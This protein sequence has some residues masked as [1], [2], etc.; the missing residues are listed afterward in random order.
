MYCCFIGNTNI[1][2]P[3]CN[4]LLV[5]KCTHFFKKSYSHPLPAMLRRCR[6]SGRFLPHLTHNK[7]SHSQGVVACLHAPAM[8][9]RRKPQS[10]LHAHA[11]EAPG[12]WRRLSAYNSPNPCLRIFKRIPDTFFTPWIRKDIGFQRCNLRNILLLVFF[13]FYYFHVFCLLTFLSFGFSILLL[14]SILL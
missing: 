3:S 8:L 11:V 9:K 10:R 2:Q 6:N 7:K 4:I 12:A 13:N 1:Q 5:T 14:G